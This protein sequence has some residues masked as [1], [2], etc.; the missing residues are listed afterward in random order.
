MS[1]NTALPFNIEPVVDGMEFNISNGCYNVT[2]KEISIFMSV[3]MLDSDGSEQGRIDFLPPDNF[4]SPSIPVKTIVIPYLNISE[5]FHW[6]IELL[7]LPVNIT[8]Y[9][10]VSEIL[11]SEEK[12]SDKVIEIERCEG[13]NILSK[14][15]TN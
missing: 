6:K 5:I 4:S 1:S 10:S 15:K 7:H 2:S 9:S 8:I 12:I 3:Y 14:L 13:N 11:G